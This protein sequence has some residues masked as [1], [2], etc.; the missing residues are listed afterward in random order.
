MTASSA[1]TIREKISR[2]G[3]SGRFGS[4]T[5]PAVVASAVGAGAVVAGTAVL[6]VRYGT[7]VFFETIVAGFNACF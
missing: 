3:M 1:R 7:A 6:W 4:T 5:R 2:K